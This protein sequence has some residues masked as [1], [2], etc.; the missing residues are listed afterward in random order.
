MM[1]RF[2]VLILLALTLMVL[3]AAAQD[4]PALTLE[5]LGTYSTGVFDEG[6]AEIVAY[7][8]AS[9]TLYVVNGDSDTIDLLDITDP[10]AL[11]LKAQID[12]TLYGGGA[13]SV[14]VYGDVVAVAIEADPKTENGVV[15]FF[16]PDGTFISQV[17][18]GALP[19]MLTFTPDGQY[20]L[21]A[22]EGEPNDDYSV[23]PEGSV[24]II[25]VSGGV[26]SLTDAN[27][28]TVSFADFNADGARAAELPSEVRVYGPNATV[29]QDLEP[30]YVAVTADSA[31][32]YVILQEANAYATLDIAS[33]AITNVFA[34][35]FKDHSVEGN[36]LDAGK[37]D[38]KINITN[39][40]LLGMYQPDGAA[41]LV[42]DGVVYLLTANEGDTRDYDGYSEEGE[43]GESAVD[44][45]F[46]NL[47]TLLTEEAILGLGVVT[48]TGDT[49]GDGDLDQLY[50]PGARSFSV[51]NADSGALVWDSGSQF[52]EI[53]AAAYPD[54]FN[55]SNDSAELDDRSDN[56][57]PEAEDIK[58]A[59]LGDK[60]YA[61]IGLERIGGV[62]VYD[63]TDPTAPLYVTYANNR[64]FAGDAEAGTAG[65]LGPEGLLIIAAENSPTGEALLVVGNEVSGSTTVFAIKMN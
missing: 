44:A 65:D 56:K 7:H 54:F 3:P 16:A 40:P 51:W 55:S 33:G 5:L 32:A 36:A 21:T 47:E 10:T 38:G 14:A 37:D 58:V 43:L 59:T 27:V 52:E 13:N 29:A 6:A 46:P 35:G 62:M 22:N 49:D 41:T 39:W 34:F 15:A 19:D 12:V 23:D 2:V 57:G 48:S 42:V 18:V 11:S 8:A 25:N 63:V 53:T 50:I 30:E 60:T 1:R 26:E 9:R 28:M 24:S 17:S 61:F 31:T 20:V 45:A 4:T 64:D